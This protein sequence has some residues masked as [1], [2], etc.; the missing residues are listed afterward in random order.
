MNSVSVNQK[1]ADT[2]DKNHRRN[3]PKKQDGHILSSVSL[4][5]GACFKSHLPVA[6]RKLRKL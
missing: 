4:R 2:A 3:R 5:D 6:Q 1:I